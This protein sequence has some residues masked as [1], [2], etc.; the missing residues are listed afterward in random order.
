MEALSE[1]GG[2]QERQMEAPS[3]VRGSQERQEKSEGAEEHCQQVLEGCWAHS[4][5]C[6][7]IRKIKGTADLIKLMVV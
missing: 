4:E 2:S 6:L 3:E 7:P 5:L 1:V